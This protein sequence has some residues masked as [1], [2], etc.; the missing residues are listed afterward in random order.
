MAEPNSGQPSAIPGRATRIVLVD[1]HRVVREALAYSLD[2]EP[3]FQV[4]GS[5]PEA[6]SALA[7]LDSASFDVALLDYSLPGMDGISAT[8]RMLQEHPQIRTLIL[9]MHCQEKLVLDAFEAGVRGFLPKDC[10]VAELTEAIR[11]VLKGDTVISPRIASQ[12]IAFCQRLRDGDGD[13]PPNPLTAIQLEILRLAASGYA[14]KEIADRTGLP[15]N[16]VKLRLKEIFTRLNARDRT[17]A[18]LVA[19]RMGLF[20]LDD[21]EG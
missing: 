10:S 2:Q 13:G 5:W 12:L 18:V 7:F 14:N 3:D 17:H 11:T 15:L 6:E 16:T 21:P 19:L 1:D 4:V 9:S 20:G 8:R